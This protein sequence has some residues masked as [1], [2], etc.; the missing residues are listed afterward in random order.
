M[1]LIF[2]IKE[3]NSRIMIHIHKIKDIKTQ[4]KKYLILSPKKQKNN[5]IDQ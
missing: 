1:Q 5:H 3:N 4:M 2:K